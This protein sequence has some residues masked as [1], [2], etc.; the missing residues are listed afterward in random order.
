MKFSNQIAIPCLS[1]L[2]E[3]K[4]EYSGSLLRRLIQEFLQ[5]SVDAG[6][7]RIVFSY[8]EGENSL[9]VADNGKGMNKQTLI[10]GLLTFG[11]SVKDSNNSCGS[12]GAAKK[13]LLFSHDNFEIKTQDLRV[14][15]QVINYNLEENHPFIYGT[16]IKIWFSSEFPR[17]SGM[18]DAIKGQLDYILGHSALSASVYY[19]LNNSPETLI[20]CR[21]SLSQ[22]EPEMEYQSAQIRSGNFTNKVIIRFK[23]LYMFESWANCDKGYYYDCLLPSKESLTQNREGFRSD[24]PADKQYSEF[25]IRISENKI[26]GIQAEI[27]HKKAKKKEREFPRDFH[28]IRYSGPDF[29]PATM[30]NKMPKR[31]KMIFGICAA[32]YSMIHNNSFGDSP[33]LHTDNFGFWY[34]FNQKGLCSDGKMWINPSCFEGEWNEDTIFNLIEVFIHEYTHWIGEVSHNESFILAFGR[35][36]VKFLGFYTGISNVKKLGSAM[37][38]LLL[39]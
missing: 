22:T 36:W 37:E 27:D 24:S 30:G 14:N 15:G 34:S 12:F 13:L 20:S 9:M 38:G 35:Y 3:A 7:E 2:R 19:S 5:N 18:S 4:Q 32:V 26:S 25:Y 23:G 31:H 6:A 29:E 16:E 11:G 39:K 21:P 8:N 28:G 1:F 17:P 33:L 10:D